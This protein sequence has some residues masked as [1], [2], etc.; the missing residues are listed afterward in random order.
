MT[1]EKILIIQTAFLGD[2][3]LTLPV[4]QVLKNKYPE[5]KI[6]FLCIPRTSSLLKNNPYVNEL[7]VYDKRQTGVK[8]LISLIRR[9]RTF[10][11]DLIITPHRSFRTSIL[12]YFSGAKDTISFDKSSFSF[13][14]SKRV[15]YV[16]GIHEIQR[17]L[18]LL[19]PL[20]I[21]EDKIIRPELFQAE[22]ER[23]KVDQFLESNNISPE[24]NII[25]IAPGSVWFTKRF[26]REK[27]V[28]LCDLLESFKC[29]IILIGGIEDK[30][31]TEFILGNSRNKSIIDTAGRFN[32]LDSAELIK[33]SSLLITNDSAP[34]HVANAV[35]TNVIA[36]FGAT[37]PE[38][39]FYPYGKRDIIFQTNGLNCRPCSIHGGNKCPIGTF[40]CMENI[41]EEEIIESVKILSKTTI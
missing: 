3:I 17:N 29:K 30:P 27:F 24:D 40:V 16:N 12:S 2:V 41:K 25:S 15:I 38:F 22:Q 5:S 8:Y 18:K 14:Y 6:D 1:F 32:I 21:R 26:P 34:L 7:I 20:G 13:L 37:I 33:R 4:L 28:K 19:E 36:V 9:L 31:V 39:G 11:Y 35:E 10:K 23:K